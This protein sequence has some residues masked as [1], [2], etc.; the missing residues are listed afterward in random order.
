[1]HKHSSVPEVV[2]KRVEL[3]M[4]L[5]RD[6]VEV[7]WSHHPLDHGQGAGSQIVQVEGQYP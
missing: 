3:V 5:Q 1:M 6:L 7:P 2:E 4:S